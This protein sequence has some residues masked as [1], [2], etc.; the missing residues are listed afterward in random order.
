[1]NPGRSGDEGYAADQAA[2][3]LKAIK[4]T[5]RLSD[6]KFFIK[7]NIGGTECDPNGG[8]DCKPP[9]F[10]PS[11]VGVFKNGDGPTVLLR[12]DMD[13]LPVKEKTE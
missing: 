11:V 6:D 12:A 2:G 4:G 1:M 10:G 7:R 8:A 13:A 9:S 3:F 5:H